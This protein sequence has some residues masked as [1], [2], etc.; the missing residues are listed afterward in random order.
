MKPSFEIMALVTMTAVMGVVLITN[1]APVPKPTEDC[2]L[3]KVDE[4]AV[5]AFVLKPPP[6]PVPVCPVAEAPKCPP[7]ALPEIPVEEAKKV[8][9]PPRR[10]RYRHRIRH[11]WR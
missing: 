3:F 1:T 7:Q 5:T 4:K 2:K 11:Y 10:K 9:D 6:A 8:D